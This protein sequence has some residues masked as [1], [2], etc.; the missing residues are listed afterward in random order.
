MFRLT[1]NICKVE[2]SYLNNVNNLVKLFFHEAVRQ[3]GDMILMRHDLQWF[4]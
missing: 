2:G 4:N 1:K 3:F